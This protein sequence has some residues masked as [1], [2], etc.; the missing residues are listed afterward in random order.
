MLLSLFWKFRFSTIVFT[1]IQDYAK[2][3]IY[4]CWNMKNFPL[5]QCL[6]PFYNKILAWKDCKGSEKAI[7]TCEFHGISITLGTFGGFLL[8]DPVRSLQRNFTRES[9]SGFALYRYSATS[10]S[11]YPITCK[12]GNHIWASNALDVKKILEQLFTGHF[13][14][15]C[16][17]DFKL[18]DLV[19]A[20]KIIHPDLL[21]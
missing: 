20:W 14:T 8:H 4:A 10:V 19:L 12:F 1:T 18:A 6:A 7:E 2:W 13:H 15:H 3:Y 5:K 17:S 21:V 9:I 11:E 16:N